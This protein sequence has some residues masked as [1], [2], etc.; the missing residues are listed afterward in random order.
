VLS[1]EAKLAGVRAEIDSVANEIAEAEYSAK[2]LDSALQAKRQFALQNEETRLKT[3]QQDLTERIDALRQAF[4]TSFTRAAPLIMHPQL[5]ATAASELNKIAA[6]PNRRLLNDLKRIF[7]DLPERLFAVPPFPEPPLSQEQERTLR[8]KLGRIMD[9]YQPEAQDMTAGLFRIDAKRAETILDLANDMA[10]DERQRSQWV[11]ELTTLRKLHGE[12][13]E[14]NR[15]LD[16]VSNLAPSERELF[17]QKQREREQVTQTLGELMTRR[18][19]LVEREKSVARELDNQRNDLR[20]EERKLGGA[21]VARNKLSCGQSLREALSLYR[22]LLKQRRRGDIEG[23]IN[24]RFRELMTSHALIAKIQVEEDFSLRYLDAAQQPVGMGNLSAGMKQ[25]V[26]QALLWGL[27]DVSRK[28]AAVVVDTPLARIDREHQMNLLRR[29]YPQ[30]GR[31]VIILPT[32][33]EID[34]EKYQMLQ[35]HIYREYRL[36]NAQGDCTRV[37]PG[38]DY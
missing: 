21:N 25:L 26:A 18:G 27:K 32:D 8:R 20:Q 29:Y 31:Q 1:T 14:V 7:D 19:E 6:H 28:E 24:Q 22:H 16:D 12:L 13:A 38:G 4:F 23:A 36:D 15:K 37:E 33:A 3:K 10:S 9:S 11:A 30:A 34:R 2:R 5:M 35:P 17:A